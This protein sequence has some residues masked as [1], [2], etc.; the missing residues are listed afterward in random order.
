M[1]FLDEAD[2]PVTVPKGAVQQ[3]CLRRAPQDAM[4]LATMD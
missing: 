3:A 1:T 4:R 2:Q